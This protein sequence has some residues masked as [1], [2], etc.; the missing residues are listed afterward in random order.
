MKFSRILSMISM[1]FMI[2]MWIFG[3]LEYETISS[4]QELVTESTTNN[5][6]TCNADQCKTC[7]YSTND[8]ARTCR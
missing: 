3:N 8:Q 6:E 2:P 4:A 1:I 7:P 5:A